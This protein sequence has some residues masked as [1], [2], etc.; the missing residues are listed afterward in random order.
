MHKLIV[1]SFA[2]ITAV[3]VATAAHDFV[4]Q[5]MAHLNTV[6]THGVAR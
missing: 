5:A 2:A 1:A 6:L 3:Y 4:A